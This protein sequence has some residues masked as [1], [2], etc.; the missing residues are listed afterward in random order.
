MKKL[1]INFI[2]AFAIVALMSVNVNAQNQSSNTIPEV[3]IRNSDGFNKL[4]GLLTSNFDYTNPKIGQGT[5]NSMVEFDLAEDGKITNI[6]AKGD[7]P[8]VSGEIVN[9]M[10]SLLYKVDISKMKQEDLIAHYRMPIIVS[11]SK[12]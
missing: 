4:R 3:T 9:T 6:K 10:N 1:A 2:G 11:V 8:H 12:E 5:F 7:C